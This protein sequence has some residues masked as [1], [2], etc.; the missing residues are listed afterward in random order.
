[1]Y[2]ACYIAVLKR[3]TRHCLQCYRRM[4]HA[5]SADG[6]AWPTLVALLPA[7]V[8]LI[9]HVVKLLV[10]VALLCTLHILVMNLRVVSCCTSH[11]ATIDPIS[12]Q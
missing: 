2:D 1:M 9:R 3:L 12:P 6:Q 5:W 8:Q 10:A 7:V 4:M 11:S